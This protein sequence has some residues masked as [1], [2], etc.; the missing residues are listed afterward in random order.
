MR[1]PRKKY[2]THKYSSLQRNIPFEL[3]FEQWWDIWQQSGKWE[4]RGCRKGQ[5]C[6][7]RKGD[8]G[9]YSVDNVFIQLSS[10]NAIDGNKGKIWS[11]ERR[12]KEIDRFIDSLYAEDRREKNEA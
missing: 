12:E 8:V 2:Y 1:S 5:Y 4:E 3:T 6:M 7:S 10:Q 11:K 9:P